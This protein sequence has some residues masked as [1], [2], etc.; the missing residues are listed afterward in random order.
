MAD[1]VTETRPHDPGCTTHQPDVPTHRP[2]GWAGWPGAV[3][4]KGEET[5][6]QYARRQLTNLIR[7]G[8]RLAVLGV[9]DGLRSMGWWHVCQPG[10]WDIPQGLSGQA[11]EEGDDLTYATA[12]CGRRVVSNGYA[13]DWRPPPGILC[14]A[15]AERI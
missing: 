10:T 8:G 15:C 13:A 14:P 6:E 7:V 1:P 4:L 9:E 2:A 12:L 5:A 11:G 3:L